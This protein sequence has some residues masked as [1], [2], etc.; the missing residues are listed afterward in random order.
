MEE[1]TPPQITVF[2]QPEGQKLTLPR[3]KTVQQLLNKLGL[4]P[5]ACLVIRHPAGVCPDEPFNHAAHTASAEQAASA[6]LDMS[7]TQAAPVRDLTA[8]RGAALLTHDLPLLA[9]DVLTIRRVAS[10][11]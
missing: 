5:C 6:G 11:G 2:L 4:R 10:S 9:G 3:P 1:R 8:E 7:D